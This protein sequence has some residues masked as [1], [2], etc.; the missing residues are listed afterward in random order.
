M[1]GLAGMGR[2]PDH[3]SMMTHATVIW[4]HCIMLVWCIVLLYPR[5]TMYPVGCCA[6]P[7]YVCVWLVVRMCG[8]AYMLCR[9]VARTGYGLGWLCSG[10]GYLTTGT[11]A[12]IHLY[13]KC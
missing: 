7:G 6:V 8:Q 9:L 11:G 1:A 4:L 3:S 2:E 5:M 10:M 12:G 13:I